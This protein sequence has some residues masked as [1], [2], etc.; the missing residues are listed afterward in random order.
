MK[1]TKARSAKNLFYNDGEGLPKR[2]GSIEK[3]KMRIL[4]YWWY[5]S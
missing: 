1:L 3:V 2:K 4:E 5:V